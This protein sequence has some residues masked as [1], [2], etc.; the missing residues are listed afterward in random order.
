MLTPKPKPTLKRSE[1]PFRIHGTVRGAFFTDRDAEV[2]KFIKVLRE[3][4]A[5]LLV[6]GHR[7]MG[8]SST[9]ERAVEQVNAKGGHA[10]LAD[11]STATTV[12]DMS[13]RILA[14]AA[15]AIGTRWTTLASDLVSR[16]QAGIKITPDPLTGAVVPSF[17]VGIRHESTERQ[18][19][20]LANVLDTMNALAEKRGKVLGV[21]LDEFQEITRWG[22]EQ[23]EWHLRGVMQ[24]HQH[25][26]YIVAGSKP[27]MITSMVEQGRAFYELFDVFPFGAI[28]A[29]HLAQWIDDRLR[30]VGLQPQAA[31]ALCVQLA[32][33]RT[34]DVVR[35]ARKCVDRA[36]GAGSIDAAAAA[37]AFQEVIDE[38]DE[39]T[40]SWWDGLTSSQQNVLRAV[41]VTEQGLTTKAVRQR[42]SLDGS[43]SVT[44]T[45][46]ALVGDG[47]LMKTSNGSGYAFDNPFV[48][49]WVIANAVPDL[50]LQ[51]P[52]T[53]IASPTSEYH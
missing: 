44:N 10:F 23:A 9:L 7:R 4:A 34:R 15:R 43:G 48:R 49:G 12:V 51:L 31:G 46:K 41:S 17:E 38:I 11:L 53:H 22:G 47:R 42:F 3:P 19:A 18:Q 35:L 52:I 24:R 33:A 29:A 8:K 45:L 2:A 5:K 40:H 37:A 13:N 16:I 26:S 32:G 14:G 36:N 1:N 20:S 39:S 30:G 25:L 28:N 21:V 27:A 50:G 6:Y